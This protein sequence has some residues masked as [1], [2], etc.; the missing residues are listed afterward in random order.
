MPECYREKIDDKKQ[1]VVWDIT[2]SEIELYKD[3]SLSKNA[4]F[5]Y[6]SKKKYCS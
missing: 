5:I 4:L 6:F 3:L 2:E 1:I